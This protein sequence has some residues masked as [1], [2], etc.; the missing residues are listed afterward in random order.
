MHI[1][2]ITVNA[3]YSNEEQVHHR[4]NNLNKQATYISLQPTLDLSR[5]I[6]QFQNET[7]N[8]RG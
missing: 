8:N 7:L 6:D 4:M 3:S 2:I 1:D 5:S